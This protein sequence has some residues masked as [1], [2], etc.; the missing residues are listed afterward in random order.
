[1]N[2][3]NTK[4]NKAETFFNTQV[5]TDDQRLGNNTVYIDNLN[6]VIFAA[7]G[8][9]A[10]GTE[11]INTTS[12]GKTWKDGLSLQD[13]FD[14][15]LDSV[16]VLGSNNL[17]NGIKI[18][19]G[20]GGGSGGD[21][22]V[23]IGASQG[24]GLATSAT[25]IND[26]FIQFGGSGTGFNMGN[27]NSAIISAGA[28]TPNSLSIIGMSNGN[29]PATRKID[30]SA[31][32]GLSITGPVNINGS[33][34]FTGSVPLSLSS[35]T[36]AA[37]GTFGDTITV[38]G[39]GTNRFNGSVMVDT[40]LIVANSGTAWIK[41]DMTLEKNLTSTNA[42]VTNSF[43]GNLNIGKA[44]QCNNIKIVSNSREN[45]WNSNTGK[46]QFIISADS[47]PVTEGNL[48]I[49]T[50]PWPGGPTKTYS[51]INTRGKLHILCNEELYLKGTSVK[52]DCNLSTGSNGIFC[53]YLQCNNT[54]GASPGV[55]YFNGLQ[56]GWINA[57]SLSVDRGIDAGSSLIKTNHI[58][59][60]GG[61][62]TGWLQ[63]GR[64]GVTT[65]NDNRPY[66]MA[67]FS[68][69]LHYNWEAI[70]V[71]LRNHMKATLSGDCACHG[72]FLQNGSVVSVLGVCINGRYY[73]PGSTSGGE[74]S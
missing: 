47:I 37:G 40:T 33:L 52:V 41:G 70:Y 43:A 49:I 35:L 9:D 62:Q 10:A 51:T 74:R 19:N 21:T 60:A 68:D 27:S 64:I 63:A 11:R 56:S 46:A 20:S 22:I 34:T 54:N 13:V 8:L 48:S 50:H 53:T 16:G 18:N 59:Q 69:E 24:L 44:I 65:I 26:K 30:M 29:N 1:M 2:E 39:V 73:F 45:D 38:N 15:K 31:D 36:V 32:A 58:V 23:N 28:I 14:T 55:G 66:H 7:S 57:N 71:K 17:I 61:M 4:K 12:I 5:L 25:I 3:Q 72:V 6:N 42:S 67:I